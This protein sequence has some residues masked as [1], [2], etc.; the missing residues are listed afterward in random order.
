MKSAPP[1]YDWV[2][3]S[4]TLVKGET[5]SVVKFSLVKNRE[6]IEIGDH[7]VYCKLKFRYFKNSNESVVQKTRIST[8]Y[9]SIEPS[10][11]AGPGSH[12]NHL[13]NASDIATLEVIST[14]A[15]WRPASRQYLFTS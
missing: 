11:Q 8:K 5:Y 1:G 9:R 3:H 13:R 14:R 2:D 6:S 15:N 4:R 7:P 12:F 10:H